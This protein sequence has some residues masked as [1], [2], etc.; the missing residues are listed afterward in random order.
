VA[1]NQAGELLDALVDL[2]SFPLIEVLAAERGQDQGHGV[3]VRIAP[4]SLEAAMSAD[5]HA[6]V[7]LRLAKNQ[8]PMIPGAIQP[9]QL[10]ADARQ[11]GPAAVPGAVVRAAVITAWR[12]H[13]FSATSVPCK[14]SL[15]E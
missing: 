5:R 10:D 6:A 7:S 13:Q 12:A 15:P 8:G 11:A 1:G 2:A 4:A 3:E 9:G 14:R